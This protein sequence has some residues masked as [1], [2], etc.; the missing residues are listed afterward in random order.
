MGNPT[1]TNLPSEALSEDALTQLALDVRWSWNHSTDEL[2]KKL[3]PELWDLTHNPWIVL[4]T[5]SRRRLEAV[6]S[7]PEFQGLLGELMEASRAHIECP[8]WFEK[9]YPEEYAKV[10]ANGAWFT[11]GTGTILAARCKEFGATK[12]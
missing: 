9:T 10:T 12:P 4:Q 2:W 8:C 1:Y 5:V 3:N 6:T 11:Q 7:D